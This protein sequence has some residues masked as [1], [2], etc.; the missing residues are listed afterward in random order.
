M[1]MNMDL[2]RRTVSKNKKEKNIVIIK[3]LK[4][5]ML[6]FIGFFCTCCRNTREN[7][8]EIGLYALRPVN[9]DYTY[10]A[11]ELNPSKSSEVR[12]LFINRESLIYTD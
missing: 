7:P 4:Y 2:H 3:A 1:P 10:T 9:N 6:F 11:L 12:E 5:E 8:F